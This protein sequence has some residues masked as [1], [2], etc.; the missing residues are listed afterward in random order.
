VT[1]PAGARVADALEA[2]GGATGDADLA[3]VNLARAVVDGEQVYVPAPGE[4]PPAAADPGEG[5]VGGGV[6]GSGGPA[7]GGSPLVDLN[8]ADAATLETLPGVGPVIAERIVTWREENGPFTSV[9]EL[10]EVSGIGPAMLA[11]IRDA[12]RV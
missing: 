6:G 1:L 2:A 10:A 11:K 12:A 5:A 3:A 7:G 4:A 8:A 9:D